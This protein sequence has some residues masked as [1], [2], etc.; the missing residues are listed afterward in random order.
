MELAA[1]LVISNRVRLQ[2]RALA[3]H[4]RLMAQQ[5]RL[6]VA[7]DDQR[8][9]DISGGAKVRQLEQ[10][11]DDRIRRR[12]RPGRCSREAQLAR[13]RGID[14][15]AARGVSRAD[16]RRPC[17]AIASRAGV[18]HHRPRSRGGGRRWG[19]RRILRAHRPSPSHTQHNR[20]QRGRRHAARAPPARDP[21][22]PDAQLIQQ[23]ERA[24]HQH[25]RH[26]VGRRQDGGEKRGDHNRVAPLASQ[27][28]RGDDAEGRQN[29]DDQRQFGD[30]SASDHERNRHAEVAVDCD[31][32]GEVGAL[33]AEQ[34][35]QRGGQ[36]PLITR[37]RA[38]QEQYDADRQ[39]RDDQ[40]FLPLIQRG[41]EE[42]P[43]LVDDDRRCEQAAQRKRDFE[44]EHERLGGARED[45]P[46]P[47]QVGRD[48]PLEHVDDVDFTE[49]PPA[50]DRADEDGEQ[51]P[52]NTP[53][54]LLKMIEKRHLT[55]LRH[56]RGYGQEDRPA[57]AANVADFGA[58]DRPRENAGSPRSSENRRSAP[59]PYRRVARRAG[60]ACTART[61]RAAT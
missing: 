46:A 27:E 37:D 12:E 58:R 26:G 18:S 15:L 38:G 42:R 53:A 35:F 10:G 51:A 48:R 34:D 57:T 1:R 14:R 8:V 52:Q 44:R 23:Q 21:G 2:L 29:R 30:E 36:Q 60:P 61:E 16:A 11:I 55:A 3:L 4:V 9:G 6:A 59:V 19:R 13:G 7:L 5:N 40:P 49:Q 31:H 41:S 47:R 20:D 17:G 22:A 24:Q 32:R 39:R 25:H 33:E 45:E 50:Y 54:Q 56:C 43:D 28:L